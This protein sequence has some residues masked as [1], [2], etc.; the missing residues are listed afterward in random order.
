[1]IHHHSWDVNLG[2]GL[3]GTSG[4]SHLSSTREPNYYTKI[5]ELATNEPLPLGSFGLTAEKIDS[6]HKALIDKIHDER[7][8]LKNLTACLKGKL[9]PDFGTDN[10]RS[11]ASFLMSMLQRDPRSRKSTTALLDNAF[12]YAKFQK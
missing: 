7:E 11:L 1:L 2:A 9:A 10:V 5:F 12:L 4:H 8:M 3:S 6:E